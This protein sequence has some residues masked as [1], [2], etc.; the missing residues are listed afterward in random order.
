MKRTLDPDAGPFC[1]CGHSKSAHEH[2]RRGSD[3]SGNSNCSCPHYWGAHP[4]RDLIHEIRRHLAIHFIMAP[5][6]L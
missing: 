2:Y 3:C 5:T 4:Y 6:P 1:V